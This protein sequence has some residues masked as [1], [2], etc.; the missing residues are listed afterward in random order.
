MKVMETMLKVCDEVSVAFWEGLRLI[1]RVPFA[2][3]FLASVGLA[4]Y[5]WFVGVAYAQ[6]GQGQQ[7]QGATIDVSG[8]GIGEVIRKGVGLAILV[9]SA[10]A[11]IVGLGFL[12]SGFA[13]LRK[14]EQ[15]GYGGSP[16]MKI[17]A[18]AG[19][20]GLTPLGY[21]LFKYFWGGSS[22]QVTLPT[23]PETIVR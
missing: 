2:G 12:F 9:I 10:G 21:A 22:L 5:L 18:G 13:G 6:N 15:G 11:L 4:A 19:L 7:G 17:A 1:E 14:G 8:P 20:M 3:K 16:W 23:S